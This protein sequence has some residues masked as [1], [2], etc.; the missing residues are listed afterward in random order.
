M[1]TIDEV[2]KKIDEIQYKMNIPYEFGGISAKE[3]LRMIKEL[4][5]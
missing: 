4:V 5:K 1:T 3:G 2:L